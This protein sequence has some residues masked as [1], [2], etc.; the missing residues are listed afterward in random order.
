M[1]ITFEW[2]DGSN[3][4]FRRFY[5]ITEDYYSALVGGE[6]KRKGFIPYNLSETI[7]DVLMA[8]C[9]GVAAGCAGL[10][11][12]SGTDTEVK[13]VWVQPEFRRHGLGGQ[14]ME[15]LEEKAAVQGFARTVLQTRECMTEAVGMYE[16][17]GYHR[18]ENYPPYDRLEG[19]VC[20]AKEL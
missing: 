13:R 8:Y 3:E 6:D 10:K 11:Q 18:I 4:D 7:G 15:K 5:L 14:L 9:G 20:F 2:T 17:R 16:K 19:A 12:Y 1:D